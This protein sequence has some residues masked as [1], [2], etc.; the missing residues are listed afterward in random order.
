[1]TLTRRHFVEGALSLAG[2]ALAR[3]GFTAETAGSAAP[4]APVGPNDKLRVAVVGLLGRGKT[5]VSEW[6]ANPDAELVALADCDP[7]GLQ[8]RAPELE[9]L[10]R[11]PRFEQDFRRLLDAK[12]IDVISIAT[13]NHWHAVMAVWAMQAGKDVYVEKPCSHNVEEGR[14]ITQWARKLGRICQMGAQSRSMTGMRQAVDFIHGGGIGEVKVAHALCY[15]RRPSI[16]LVDTPA[17][18]P[19]GIDFDLWAGPAPKVVPVRKQLH[20]D[21]HWNQLTGNGDLGNQNPHEIDK[22]RWGLGKKDLPRRVVSLGG[23]LGYVDNGDTAN[24]QVTLF[25]WDDALIISDVRGLEIKTPPTIARK[26]GKLGV[27]N[28]WW[29]TKGYVVT[30]KYNAGVAFDYDGNELAR[31]AGGTDQLHFA[32]FVAGVRSRNP[33]DLHLDIEQGHVS[34]AIAHIG[35][36]S[37]QLGDVV[38]PG[39]KP[40]LASGDEHV[41]E[42]FA[43]LDSHLAANGVDFAATPLKLGRVLTIDPVT[44]RASDPEANALFGRE[45]RRGYELPRV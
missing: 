41:R 5:H 30:P 38:P 17:P 42:T 28:I 45:Y 34:S 21:W 15:K 32:N 3:P 37:W 6:I 19:P 8:K 22:A 24:T 36:V 12:D 29:G 43:T 16:G 25:Q 27:A 31:W 7:A 39:T 10:S 44:E 4:A 20:Y 2:V 14:V 18:L 9:G 13:P 35:N 23:R 1:M 33:A 40:E 26:A 11:Q